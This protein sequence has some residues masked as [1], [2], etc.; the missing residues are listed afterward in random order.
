M[1]LPVP[2]ASPATP[3]AHGPLVKSIGLAHLQGETANAERTGAIA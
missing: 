3:V 2:R 1:V